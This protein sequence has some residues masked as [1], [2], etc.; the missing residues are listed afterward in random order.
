MSPYSIAAAPDSSFTKRFNWF[1]IGCL[2]PKVVR[3]T[4][5]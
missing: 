3:G 4:T 5:M 1:N 2:Y